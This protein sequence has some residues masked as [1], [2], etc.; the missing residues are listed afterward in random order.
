MAE[1]GDDEDT[2]KAWN[3]VIDGEGTAQT[4][5]GDGAP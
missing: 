5:Q 4:G 1:Q 2:A 3:E